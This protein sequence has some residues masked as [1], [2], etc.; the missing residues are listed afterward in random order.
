MQVVDFLARGGDFPITNAND[1]DPAIQPLPLLQGV[2]SRKADV[3]NFLLSLTDPRVKFER[4]PF[5]HPEIFVPIDARAPVSPG[6]R[7][8][9]LSN[10]TMFQQ[11]PAVGFAGRLAEGLPPWLHF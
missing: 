5:D 8:G 6:N 2:P 10:P 1:I 9:F 3:V 4:E 11:I 7:A